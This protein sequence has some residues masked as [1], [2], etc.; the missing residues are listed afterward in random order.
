MN[1]EGMNAGK[2]EIKQLPEYSYGKGDLDWVSIAEWANPASNNIWC[3]PKS[4]NGMKSSTQKGACEAM[5]CRF[6]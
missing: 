3:L 2:E 6:S 5:E 1:G 4:P